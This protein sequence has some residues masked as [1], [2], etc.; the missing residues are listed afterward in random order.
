[1][2]KGSVWLVVP[3]A[4]ALPTVAITAT[5][6]RMRSSTASQRLA[7]ALRLPLLAATSSTVALEVSPP[8][9]DTG[10]LLSSIV[11]ASRHRL[12]LALS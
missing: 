7:T 12:A 9:S 1:M 3:M 6:Q 11:G 5:K 2:K 4:M 10:A 8:C